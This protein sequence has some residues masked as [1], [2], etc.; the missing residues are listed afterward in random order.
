MVAK[1][2]KDHPVRKTKDGEEI[3]QPPSPVSRST[4]KQVMRIKCN[5]LIALQNKTKKKKQV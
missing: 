1:L 5:T 2:T 3:V 4:I